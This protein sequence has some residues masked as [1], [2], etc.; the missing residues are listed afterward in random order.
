MRIEKKKDMTKI[1]PR[2]PY[3][4]L[5]GIISHFQ[6]GRINNVWRAVKGL[7]NVIYIP[8]M[9]CV[10]LTVA[11]QITYLDD[12]PASFIHIMT[13]TLCLRAHSVL[14]DSSSEL[15]IAHKK[16]EQ[17]FWISFGFY[18]ARQTCTYFRL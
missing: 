10:C 6:L 16:T 9:R 15:G 8:S 4:L 14:D 5:L 3:L 18:Y 2:T 1:F 13:F 7:T 12:P 11:I 17:W